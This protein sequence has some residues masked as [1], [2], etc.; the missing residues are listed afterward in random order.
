MLTGVKLTERDLEILRFINQFGFCEMPHVDKRFRLGKPRNY[1]IIQ[2]L[3]KA[4]LVHH[5]RVFHGRH[6]IYRLSP[7]GAK[8]TDLPPLARVPLA[9]YTHDITLIEVYLKL[10]ALHPNAQWISERHLMQD[11]HANGVGKRGHLPDGALVFPDQSQVAIEVELTLK[12]KARL[13]SILKG[14]GAAFGYKEVWYYCPDRIA[15]NIAPMVAKM[16][17]IKIYP[18]K[19][20]LG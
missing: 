19:E 17:F 1:Q 3:V 7:K 14:Y 9:N 10:R 13:E 4:G 18:L 8:L 11:K 20:L 6:G 2:R 5:E 15:A 16:P 12:G